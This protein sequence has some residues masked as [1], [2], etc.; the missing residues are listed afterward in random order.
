[1]AFSLAFLTEKLKNR[2]YLSAFFP[3]FPFF[4]RAPTSPWGAVFR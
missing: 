4:P 2:Q 1:M 3:L